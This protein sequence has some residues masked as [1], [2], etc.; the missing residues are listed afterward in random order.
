MRPVDLLPVPGRPARLEATFNEAPLYE[1]DNVD[2]MLWWKH[3]RH[4]AG[5]KMPVNGLHE[6]QVELGDPGNDGSL[7]LVR[8]RHQAL[9][10]RFDRPEA[11]RR[12]LPTRDNQ[13]YPFRVVRAVY[14]TAPGA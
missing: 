2:E 6:M 8:S 3:C 10:F 1:F 11:W 13:T 14:D 7:R 4:L 9:S 12:H 5:P